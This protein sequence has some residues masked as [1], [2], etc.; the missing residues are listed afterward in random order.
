MK[1]EESKIVV[2][3][4]SY[5]KRNFDN[6]IEG[7]FNVYLGEDVQELLDPDRTQGCYFTGDHSYYKASEDIVRGFCCL[8]QIGLIPHRHSDSEV[9]IV[10]DNTIFCGESKEGKYATIN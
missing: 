4:F 6:Q 5:E 9:Y 10:T 1:E 7:N 2:G 3:L 8:S